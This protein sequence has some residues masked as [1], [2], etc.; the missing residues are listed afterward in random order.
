MLPT[1][2]SRY[3][4][5]CH[6]EPATTA[7]SNS[8]SPR[9][10]SSGLPLPTAMTRG[11]PPQHTTTSSTP[12]TQN[13]YLPFLGFTFGSPVKMKNFCEPVRI[14]PRSRHRRRESS[15][16]HA[17]SL[18]PTRHMRGS[19]PSTKLHRPRLLRKCSRLPLAMLRRWSRY[20][21]LHRTC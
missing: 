17:L 21:C 7:V 2:D 1:T 20:A 8:L 6:M 9:T 11:S 12:Q 10:E 16:L 15:L 14:S 3:I 4:C 5:V 18:L 13:S 19:R